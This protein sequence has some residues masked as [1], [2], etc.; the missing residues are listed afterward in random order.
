MQKVAF[1]A[2]IQFLFN[3]VAKTF[4]GLPHGHSSQQL[5]ADIEAAWQDPVTFA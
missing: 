5:K 2:F 4:H 3:L 1:L